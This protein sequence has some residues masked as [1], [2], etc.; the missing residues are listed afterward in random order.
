MCKGGGGEKFFAI[1]R[2][3]APIANKMMIGFVVQLGQNFPRTWREE[4]FSWYY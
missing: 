4:Q 1:Y 2:V 3:T